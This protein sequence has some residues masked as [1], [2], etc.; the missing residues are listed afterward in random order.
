MKIDSKNVAKVIIKNNQGQ[1]LTLIRSDNG[2]LDIPGGHLFVNESPIM[3]A[4]RETF[5]E[6][7]LVL[8]NINEILN[9][10]RK[11][12][13]E[14]NNYASLGKESEIELDLKENSDYEWMSVNSFLK[15]PDENAT[16]VITAYKAYIRDDEKFWDKLR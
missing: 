6:T 2:K 16:D 5:E 8:L 12:I 10:K 15:I 3:G 7:K 14:S 13:F 4:I 11:T 9:Y 1:I